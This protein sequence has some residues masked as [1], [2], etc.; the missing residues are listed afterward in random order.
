MDKY[1]TNWSVS[2]SP[3]VLLAD[4]SIANRKQIK[5]LL[6]PLNIQI[7]EAESGRETLQLVSK[8]EF[9]AILLDV[10]M[11]DIN[12]LETAGALVKK[13]YAQ[14][15]PIL[16]LSSTPLE[17]RQ[18]TLGYEAGAVDFIPWA[19]IP[20]VLPTKLKFYLSYYVQNKALEE[21]N[22][23]KSEFLS[24]MSHE[25]RTPLNSILVLA[26]L[27][28]DNTDRNLT[29]RQLKFAKTIYS[30]GTD[31]LKLINEI[32]DLSKVESG[33]ME[34]VLDDI[35]I[36]EITEDIEQKITH[37]ATNKGLAFHIDIA[38]NAPESIYTDTVRVTQIL[39][40]LLSNAIKFTSDG[41]VTLRVAETREPV[42]TPK[43]TLAPG[44]AVAF[45]VTDTGIGVPEDKKNLIFEAFRQADGSIRRQYG[46]TGLGL[47]ISKKLANIMGGEL[48]FTPAK[49]GGS[50]F[51]LFLPK[52]P[53]NH[54]RDS[55]Q[56]E[57]DEMVTQYKDPT[58]QLNNTGETIPPK[59]SEKLQEKK[60]LL[61]EDDIVNVYVMLAL[62]DK[63]GIQAEVANNGNAALDKLS[64]FSPD[65]ILM[66]MM[67]PE[68]DG[69]E[70]TRQIKQNPA[71]ATIPIVAVTAKAMKG[72]KEK[73]FDAGVDG[74]ITKPVLATALFAEMYTCLQ[75]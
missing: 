35:R 15:T 40:N 20:K 18:I 41:T 17:Q 11:P 9:G 54:R 22:R 3:K 6:Q 26:Q 56:P 27:L 55:L 52:N 23:T 49:G 30:S 7:I 32:L 44:S 13:K 46:G 1:L 45:S 16:L 31:L 14:H 25:L 38:P 69:Y 51:T 33:M 75:K 4:D 43:Y 36:H 63:V 53:L 21:A 59:V 39:N 73:C 47:S 71:W 72:D 48:V 70:A 19:D 2:E 68:M 58:L 34:F 61:V 42:E 5:Q 66:D 50:T 28:K 74:Y 57:R 64:F 60:V 8:Y 37:T 67:M 12:G 62:L 24:N 29:E 10:G 65:V